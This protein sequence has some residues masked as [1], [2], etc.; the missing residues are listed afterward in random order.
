MADNATIDNLM[1]DALGM[2][3]AGKNRV[4]TNKMRSGL[5]KIAGSVESKKIIG[6]KLKRLADL[7]VFGLAE[8]R[9]EVKELIRRGLAEVNPNLQ[10]PLDT[11][12]IQE[13]A[14]M[15]MIIYE[16][17]ATQRMDALLD[18]AFNGNNK[19]NAAVIKAVMY[20][21]LDT[22]NA[23]NKFAQKFG[24]SYITPQMQQQL[25]NAAQQVVNA[26][27]NAARSVAQASF[28]SMFNNFIYQSKPTGYKILSSLK[29]FFNYFENIFYNTALFAINTFDRA[30]QGNILRTFGNILNAVARGDFKIIADSFK[31]V[32]RKKNVSF[33][34]TDR[35]GNVQSIDAKTRLVFDDVY[36]S[37][38]G[39]PRLAE[40]KRAGG[41]TGVEIDIRNTDSRLKR[42]FLRTLA[43]PASRIMGAVDATVMPLNMFLTKRQAFYD[44]LKA[45]Y[46][47][48]G[49]A[50]S[51]AQLRTQLNDILGVDT[52]YITK[53]MEQAVVDVMGS[54]LWTDLGFTNADEFPVSDPRLK[55]GKGSRESKIYNEF[56]FRTREIL[57]SEENKRLQDSF[58]K[59]GY[60][61]LMTTT[62]SDLMSDAIDNYAIRVSSELAFL[63]T[64]R[65]SLRTPAESISKLSNK[66]LP[67]KYVGLAPLFTNAAFNA[68]GMAIRVTPGLNLVQYLKYLYTGSR[69]AYSK[70]SMKEFGSDYEALTKID[71]NKML[72]TVLL[73]NAAFVIAAAL[74]PYDDKEEEIIAINN[75]M[76]TGSTP[77]KLTKAQ[78]DLGYLPG[79]IYIKGKSYDYRD[80]PLALL[81]G[82]I[83]FV[84]NFGLWSF[85]PQST[86]FY[87]EDD[88]EIG[89]DPSFIETAGAYGLFITAS[90]LE[91]ST[92]KDM[93]KTYSD[94]IEILSPPK[95]EDDVKLDRLVARFLEKKGANIIRTSIPY[96]RFVAE[97]KTITDAIM[98]NDK[99]LPIEFVDNIVFGHAIEDVVIKTN[100]Y[101]FFGRPVK[102]A[103]TLILPFVSSVTINQDPKVDRE[104]R[105]YRKM[106]YSPKLFLNDRLPVHITLDDL[107]G[108]AN[109]FE[110]FFKR[111][112][113]EEKKKDGLVEDVER[114]SMTEQRILVSLPMSRQEANLVNQKST[115]FAGK[116]VEENFINLQSMDRARFKDA[117]NSIYNIGR[118][119][120]I[121]QNLGNLIEYD[122]A[123]YYSMI[124][125]KIIKFKNTYVGSTMDN[126]VWPQEFEP[127]DILGDSFETEPKVIL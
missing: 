123:D 14:E 122:K 21:A 34:Y 121:Y 87:A 116:F 12:E 17:M 53:A 5:R 67:L 82:S 98:N 126:L 102:D 101:D 30:S 79:R 20:G 107:N 13:M 97:M 118:E 91:L 72:R 117:M 68:A 63:G 61:G 108:D 60:G 73:T 9:E 38:R 25:R 4:L 62:E 88:G 49:I 41:L 39:L 120:A 109:K 105:L 7:G 77:L 114:K 24:L 80:N 52:D 95:G 46:K 31:D 70:K 103:F 10:T 33:N 16:E 69:G 47:D 32:Y 94:L 1:I 26:R 27:G 37:L 23:L 55:T 66:F 57:D 104:H 89:Y 124:N 56:L 74:K 40:V 45:F 64:P 54:K 96:T 115:E 111:V 125:N 85:D 112:K 113:A 86:N 93:S 81:I 75:M 58:N 99:K 28:T 22:P 76:W 8:T 78:T 48:K 44:V 100:G 11:A 29:S 83:S 119:V 6:E 3:K 92:I 36:S 106:N 2:D 15:F 84:R 42:R 59:M 71:Q 43:V 65:G 127:S 90:M 35:N 50:I 18:K 19:N 51:N 110:D